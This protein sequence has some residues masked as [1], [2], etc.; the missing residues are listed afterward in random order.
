MDWSKD[1][2]VKCRDE[3]IEYLKAANERLAKD[4]TLVRGYWHEERKKREKAEAA[5][6]KTSPEM[7]E[8]L[9]YIFNKD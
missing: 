3:T 2:A 8:I 7:A 4:L 9:A 6:E 1:D 5:L